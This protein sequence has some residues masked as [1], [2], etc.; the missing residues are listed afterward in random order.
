MA[1][2]RDIDAHRLLEITGFGAPWLERERSVEP[3]ATLG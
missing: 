1:P 2:G 3:S